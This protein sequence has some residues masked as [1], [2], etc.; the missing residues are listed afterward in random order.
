VAMTT[1]L[2]PNIDAIPGAWVVT[3]TVRTGPVYAGQRAGVLRAPDGTRV[4]VVAP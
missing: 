4:E 3:P 2:H 1:L